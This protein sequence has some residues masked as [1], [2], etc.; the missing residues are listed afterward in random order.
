MASCLHLIDV[1]GQS[2]K[3]TFPEAKHKFNFKNSFGLTYEAEEVRKCI[4]SGLLQSSTMSHEDS[5]TN[6]R[7][8][9]EIRRQIG[10]VYEAD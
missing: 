5:L 2:K 6:T 3:W 10:V 4:R 9:E 8:E 7:I 1:D